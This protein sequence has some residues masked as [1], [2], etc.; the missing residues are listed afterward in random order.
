LAA[1]SQI[2]FNS[3]LAAV[4]LTWPL[5]AA[6]G[7]AEH[8]T[9]VKGA[10][11]QSLFAGKEF[12]DGVHFAY[13]FEDDGTFTGTEMAKSVS[14]RWRVREDAFCWKWLRPPDPEA[15]YQ[16]QGDGS[17]IR[18]LMNG[19]EAWYGTLTPLP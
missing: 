6:S 17:H 3:A 14:G 9:S 7:D 10:A 8:W 16:V 13:Q 11:L 15:C 1:Q 2:S 12:G 18:M 4:V 19:S 5:L